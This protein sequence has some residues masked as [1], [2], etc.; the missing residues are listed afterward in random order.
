MAYLDRLLFFGSLLIPFMAHMVTGAQTAVEASSS[1]PTL[2]YLTR[3]MAVSA[4]LALSFSVILGMLRSVA[5]KASER[6]SWV[7]DELHQFIATLAGLFVLGHLVT[8][9]FDSFMPFS[10]INLLL[11][12]AEPYK[13]M[14]VAFGVF[15]LYAMVLLLVSSWLRRRLRYSWWRGI[16]YVSF[17]AFALVTLHG[18]LAGSDSSEPWMRAIYAASA[19]SVTFLILVRLFVGAPTVSASSRVG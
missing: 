1:S 12:V 18:W 7:V 17:V 9:K 3:A 13:P 16:H 15:G 11:P 4:Y 19:A 14:A 10:L 8:L 2:W 6:L 5:R